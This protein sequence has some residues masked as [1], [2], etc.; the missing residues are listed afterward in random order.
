MV[1]QSEFYETLFGK[2][3]KETNKYERIAIIAK[4]A[5][6]IQIERTARFFSELENLGILR[7]GSEHQIIDTEGWQETLAKSYEELPT[8][9]EQ[10]E[11]EFDEEK[12]SWYYVEKDDL[13]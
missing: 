2:V 11:Q 12:L 4:R 3:E 9:I 13:N 10:A 8:P 7:E 6:Q 1:M 5:K